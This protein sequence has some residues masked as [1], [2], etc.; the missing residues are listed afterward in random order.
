MLSA[1]LEARFPTLDF[2]IDLPY[3]WKAVLIALTLLMGLRIALALA[4]GGRLR[5]MATCGSPTAWW[6]AGLLTVSATG[7]LSRRGAGPGLTTL[8]GVMRRS[9]MAAGSWS[10]DC[11]DG[12]LGR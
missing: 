4:R 6:P 10:A 3:V 1:A 8:P 5:F 2:V 11:G 7:A 12:R 9:I